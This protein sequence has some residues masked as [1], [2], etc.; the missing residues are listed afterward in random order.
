MVRRRYGYRRS[1]AE[2]SRWWPRGAAYAVF[3]PS[4]IPE[5]L[6]PV[7][8]HLKR[9]RIIAGLIATVGVYTSVAGG[10]DFAQVME[11]VLIAGLVLM[12]ITPLTV[13]VM[14]LVWRRSGPL[15]ALKS[16]LL[17]SLRVLLCFVGA[18]VGILGILSLAAAQGG[19]GLVFSFFMAFGGIW[20]L[21]FLA[22]AAVQVNSNFFGTAAIHRCL[23]PLLATVTSWLMALPDLLT[24]DLHGLSFTM[25]ILFVLGAPVAVTGIALFEMSR[26]RR[27]HGI[28]LRAHPH[29]RIA[30]TV[31]P[32]RPPHVPAPG[33]GYPYGPPQGQPYGPPQG[34]P[35]GPPQGQPHGG[36]YPNPGN[37][38]GS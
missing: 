22:Q 2:T 34:N 1:A 29:V 15:R 21:I 11:N 14:L 9:Y 37:P 25:G 32:P 30:P 33:S 27:H 6:D 26:L 23:P 35:Y 3:H 8:D 5:P 38:Y 19:G 20:G 31:P 16:P 18:L 4:W 28:R 24:G 12:V 17:G 13:G 7:V 36:G 10:F